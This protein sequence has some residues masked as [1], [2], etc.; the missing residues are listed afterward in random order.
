MGAHWL[1]S[2]LD[3]T[4]LPQRG[5]HLIIWR[6]TAPSTSSLPFTLLYFSSQH[7]FLW[8][9]TAWTCL[10]I[11]FCPTPSI[12]M[13]AQW[14]KGF[15]S[16]CLHASSVAQSCP[17]LWDSMNYSPPD[18]SV[19]GILQARLLEWVSIPTSSE[20]S[21]PRDQTHIS[22]VSCF[23][24]QILYHCTTWEAHICNHRLA[25]VLIIPVTQ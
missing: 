19:H 15:G 21:Q 11:I 4:P 5:F 20:S 13:E 17:I 16:Q 6:R 25:V 22:C 18:F 9:V 8:D 10:F 23:G 1:H 12:G 7:L 24:R 2:Q 14:E 3:S